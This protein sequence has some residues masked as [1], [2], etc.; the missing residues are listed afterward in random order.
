MAGQASTGSVPI[1]PAAIQ[2]QYKLSVNKPK[3]TY[4]LYFNNLFNS[5]SFF[6]LRWFFDMVPESW[7]LSGHEFESHHPLFIC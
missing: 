7:W 3:Y 5:L 2:D 1:G 6:W 4:K